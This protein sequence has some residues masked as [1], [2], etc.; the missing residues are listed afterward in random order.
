MRYINRHGN[1]Q[2]EHIRTLA[3]GFATAAT[4]GEATLHNSVLLWL[5]LR[6]LCRALN[7]FKTASSFC[8][9]EEPLLSSFRIPVQ[10]N[11][12]SRRRIQIN[13]S[14]IASLLCYNRAS[15]SMNGKQLGDQWHDQYSSKVQCPAANPFG[16]SDPINF[17]L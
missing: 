4:I 9:A 2:V 5:A 13:L 3:G 14:V 10:H 16:H 11:I 1:E 17:S 15:S 12:V 8:K 6:A 7:Y